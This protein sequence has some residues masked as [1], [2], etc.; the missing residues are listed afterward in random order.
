M[1]YKITIPFYAF[2]INFQANTHFFIPMADKEVVRIGQGFEILAGKYAEIVQRQVFD[3]GKFRQ[4]LDEFRHS[5][6]YSDT[7]EVNFP[8]A[9]DGFSYPA[10]ALSFD[11]FYTESNEG[12][13]GIVPALGLET[14][15]ASK[16]DIPKQF[17]EIIRIEFTRKK[18]L[19]AIQQII[20]TIWYDVIE[21]WSDEIE[22]RALF[23]AEIEEMEST[24][25]NPL[26]PKAA[27]LLDIHKSLA[28]GMESPLE[29]L[30]KAL[31]N[32]F[33]RSILL[34]GRRVSEKPLWFGNWRISK[35]NCVLKGKSGR[36]PLLPSSKN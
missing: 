34:V 9:K 6:Y 24:S 25:A 23:P 22:L 13:K 32:Q 8:A 21:L 31:K 19:S 18:R 15:A 14:F 3:K 12:V 16:T 26:L 5:E 30:A 17:Q 28:Y 7:L 29:Q 33:N 2:K 20:T 36:P 11:F 27:Q 35:R 4:L 10:F 1:A